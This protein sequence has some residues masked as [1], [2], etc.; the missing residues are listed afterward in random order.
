MKGVF[1]PPSIERARKVTGELL[2]LS[3]VFGIAYTQRAIYQS[4]YNQNTKYLHG[5][6]QAG[7]GYLNEDWM[8]STVDPLPA[9]TVLVKLTYAWIH[10]NFFYIYFIAICG[11]YAY[12]LIHVVGYVYNIASSRLNYSVYFAALLF[13]YTVP[14]QVGKF[15]S[16]YHLN[17]GVA[18][19]YILGPVFEPAS[20]GA[21]ILLS[22][23]LF[24]QKKPYWSVASLALAATIHPTYL[25]SAAVL[26]ASYMAIV[27][28]QTRAVGLA[29]KLGLLSVLLLLPVYSYM[30]LAFPPTTPEIGAQAQDIIVNFRI[31]HHSLPEMWLLDDR[32]NVFVQTTLVAIALFL[33]RK[34]ALFGIILIPFLTAIAF[35]MSQLIAEN[36]AIAFIAPWRMSVF[37]VPL[38]TAV[39]LG[40][41]TSQL[42]QKV[43]QYQ[44]LIFRLSLA[45]VFVLFTLGAINQIKYLSDTDSTTNL[46]EY[47][48][49]NKQSGEMYL[50]SPDTEILRKFRFY[51]GA[52]IFV[53]L[54]THPYKDVEV[55]EW[56]RRLQLAEDFYRSDEPCSTLDKIIAD[57]PLTHIINR[58]DEN[59][60]RCDALKTVYQDDRY[61]VIKLDS[62]R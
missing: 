21:F 43:P 32:S 14:I 7:M 34:T 5:L 44:K 27:V 36:D 55:L 1:S 61:E 29:L 10:P 35:T 4:S 60:I 23:H 28:T 51:T 39:I 11:I 53:N 13:A 3:L 25:P 56:Y 22:I 2:L 45:I 59:T 18:D 46:M 62:S 17:S 24:L 57:Y 41:A 42:L 49:S 58:H 26:T 47:V 19:Q 20:F 38:A 30:S 48:K 15:E 31:P 40:W 33:V 37:L 8:A 16:I 6:A 9:F 50:L 54:K 12:S 52:P